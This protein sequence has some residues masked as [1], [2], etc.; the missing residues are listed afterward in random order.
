MENNLL[1]PHLKALLKRTTDLALYTKS[2]PSL[3]FTANFKANYVPF[4]EPETSHHIVPRWCEG[5]T[6]VLRRLRE[7]LS[8]RMM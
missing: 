7:H 4:S 2:Y 1:I 3:L 5:M 6:A 8:E